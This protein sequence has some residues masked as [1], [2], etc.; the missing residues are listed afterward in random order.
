MEKAKLNLFVFLIFLVIIMAFSNSVLGQSN[1]NVL[2]VSVL[3]QV[4]DAARVLIDA[5][6]TLAYGSLGGEQS[7]PAE[8]QD[9]SVD[10][11]G[12][13]TF[14]NVQPGTYTITAKNSGYI[15]AQIEFTK[16]A[17]EAYTSVTLTKAPEGAT[18]SI[19]IALLKAY[20]PQTTEYIRNGQIEIL[21]DREVIRNSGTE[22]GEVL[23][24]DLP[25]GNYTAS[26]SVPGYDSKQM[27]FEVEA[28]VEGWL[29]I[30]LEEVGGK[31]RY[32]ACPKDCTCD[33][34]TNVLECHGQGFGDKG[35]S[36]STESAITIVK[37]NSIMEEVKDIE[38][39]E[40]EDKISYEISGTKQG[41]LL[42]FIPVQMHIKTS[43]DAETG[44]VGK[45]DNPWW[46]FLTSKI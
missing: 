16:Q 31:P 32:T 19:K 25:I 15:F 33:E 24:T 6:V 2:H 36:I 34:Q 10:E 9:I 5:K 40:D 26:A 17:G 28:N 42:F 18:G 38:L 45:I 3:E 4:G 37:D 20:S 1:E 39:K 27:T 41:K 11:T 46:S 7:I 12:Q 35:I 44:K 21:K 43:I 8:W 22:S 23:F 14:S 30:G 13:V 29:P